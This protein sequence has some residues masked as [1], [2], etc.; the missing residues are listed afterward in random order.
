[1]RVTANS[2]VLAMLRQLSI[3]G[4][5]LIRAQEQV[6]T[7]K[8]I[9]RLSDDPVD[10]GRLLDLNK[11]SD[12]AGQYQ[13]NVERTRALASV[14]EQ[15]IGQAHDLL[16]R[17]KELLLRET[18]EVSSTVSTRESTRIEIAMLT[19]QLIQ[20]GNTRYDGSYIFSGYAT[21]TPAFTEAQVA[22]VP[23]AV[24][25]DAT[26]TG[27]QVSDVTRL[28]YDDYEI[29][30]TAPGAFDVV[31]VTD[32]QVVLS[33]QAYVSGQPIRFDGVEITLTSGVGGPQAGD[34]YAVTLTPPG[35]YQGDG[36]VQQVEIQ[37]GEKVVQ[38]LPGD[39]V[40]QGVGIGGGVDVFDILHRVGQ[41][42]ESNDRNAMDQLLGEI[43][44]AREQV[45]NE[46]SKVGAR[47]NLLDQVRERH[48]EIKLQLDSLRSNLEDIDLA[49]ALTQ[50]NKQQ[51]GY[52]ATI[53]A[54]SK[55]VQVSLLDF[56]R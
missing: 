46:R 29:V 24:A 51:T 48:E 38:S 33:N 19:S 17:A 45:A 13:K 22:A 54:A 49:E 5:S 15:T 26:V 14:Q 27:V 18:N 32:A 28:T 11:L 9:N 47:M 55:I 2:N 43:D 42:L 53:T 35:V 40:F 1:M 56:L 52:E 20:L 41:A 34:T 31:D 23:S 36:Q 21:S 10:G 44:T 25:G 50:L 4:H 12:Q 7:Q 16:A 3:N 8:R 39:R 37:P 6:A 30:F